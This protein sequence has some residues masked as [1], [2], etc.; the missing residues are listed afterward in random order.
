VILEEKKKLSVVARNDEVAKERLRTEKKY[1]K[2]HYEPLEFEARYGKW[3]KDY[4]T[5][6]DGKGS[7]A[8]QSKT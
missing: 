8:L 3:F 6:V 2:P 5:N 7:F 4:F 1:Q